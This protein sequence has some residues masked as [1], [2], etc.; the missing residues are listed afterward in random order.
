MA[1]RG[2]GREREGRG[3]GREGRVRIEV[4]EREIARRGTW[5]D[6]RREERERAGLQ[7]G[8]DQVPRMERHTCRR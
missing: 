6:M 8:P 5:M 7:A 4:E 1:R 2:R 3:E